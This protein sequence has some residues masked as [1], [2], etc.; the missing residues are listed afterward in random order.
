MRLLTR[1]VVAL[2]TRTRRGLDTEIAVGRIEG[3]PSPSVIN[4]DN[5]L[6]VP[7]QR[8][9]RQMGS[10]SAPRITELNAALRVA[11]EIQ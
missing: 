7:R 4:L 6:T 5:L 8:L 2:V 10:L 9:V 1:F 11:L 3:L